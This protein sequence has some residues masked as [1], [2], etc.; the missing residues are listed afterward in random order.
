MLPPGTSAAFYPAV[1]DLK[2]LELEI[3]RVE[4]KLRKLKKDN[5]YPDKPIRSPVTAYVQQR[6]K[7]TRS[8]LGLGSASAP[9]PP[10]LYKM[11]H[12]EWQEMAE[13][14]RVF[15]K[16]KVQS[17]MEMYNNEVNEWYDMFEHS[18]TV[19]LM[20]QYKSQ[21]AELKRTRKLLREA[22][23]SE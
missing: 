15:F 22:K 1:S 7:D 20:D 4:S 5:G 2:T 10:D 17:N 21:L 13:S 6:M 9:K 18:A 14:E 23:K 11:F 12:R 19:R 16:R 3:K 8:P